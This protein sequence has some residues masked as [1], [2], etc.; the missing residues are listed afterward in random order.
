MVRMYRKALISTWNYCE[1]TF[2]EWIAWKFL[3]YRYPISVYSVDW[4]KAQKLGENI[5]NQ[6]RVEADKIVEASRE[7]CRK[8]VEEAEKKIA[9]C[10]AEAERIKAASSEFR[11]RLY[12]GYLSHLQILKDMDVSLNLPSDMTLSQEVEVQTQERI[13]KAK[14]KLETIRSDEGETFIV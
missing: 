13:D 6:S 5:V 10:L 12:D 2:V 9:Q 8:N 3:F 11:Q 7:T 1:N 14:D 4:T